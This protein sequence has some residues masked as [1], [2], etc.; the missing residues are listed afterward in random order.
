VV[1]LSAGIMHMNQIVFWLVSSTSAMVFVPLA[2]IPGAL[3]G[4]GAGGAASGDLMAVLPVMVLF[5]T[6]LC[7]AL[8]WLYTIRHR[9]QTQAA[10]PPANGRSDPAE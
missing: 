3:V 10:P 8:I 7:I 2:L 4:L 5:G 1:P 9:F 6:P